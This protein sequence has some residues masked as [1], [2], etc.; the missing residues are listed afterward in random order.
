MKEINYLLQDLLKPILKNYSPIILILKRNWST[1][2][3]EKYYEF[4]EAETVYFAKNKKN[5]GTL[6]VICFN[7]VIAFYI[8]NNKSFILEKINAIFG[9][10]LIQDIKIKQQPKIIKTMYKQNKILD[11][12]I[13]NY[14][15]NVALNVDDNYLKNSLINLGKS[16]YL[17]K[18]KY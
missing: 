13:E 2:L 10:C 7:N 3:G 12:Q 11:T 9:Y 5:N 16:I 18:N 15:D 14:L 4:C 17:N 8:E 1:I 6:T